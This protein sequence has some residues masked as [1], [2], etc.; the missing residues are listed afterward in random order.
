MVVEDIL[1]FSIL[2]RYVQNALMNPNIIKSQSDGH[3]RRNSVVISCYLRPALRLLYFD[4]LS[5]RGQI[6]LTPTC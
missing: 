2:M 5:L 3:K 1:E 6:L 4:S